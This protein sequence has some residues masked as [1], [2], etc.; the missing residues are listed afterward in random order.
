MTDDPTPA[1]SRPTPSSAAAEYIRGLFELLGDRDPLAVQGELVPALRAAI[2]GLADAGLRRA[3]RAGKWSIAQVIQHLADSEIVSGYRYRAVIAQDGIALAGYDQ[4]AW[5]DRLAYGEADVEAALAAL[6]ELRAANLRLLSR[7]REEEWRR[8]G[9]HAERG[10]E[11]VRQLARLVAGHDLVHRRQIERIKTA[12]GLVAAPPAREHR[13]S[14][15]LPAPPERAF[16]ALIT[17]SAIRRWWQA[18]RAVVIAEPGGAWAA[19]WGTD[20]DDPDYATAATL[21]VFEPPRRLVL[22]DYRYR[23]RAG[24]LPF[25][26][27]FRVEFTIRAAE[28]GGS[29]LE[30]VQSGFPAGPEADAHLAGCE[31]GWRE[32]LE[33]LRRFLTETGREDR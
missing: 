23:A 19:A 15:E 28:S 30:V 11:S 9:L 7:L 32:T 18:D 1:D 33:G 26:A 25:E 29:V 13:R 22:A 5:A 27:D 17:P 24:R 16:V 8:A 6:A 14:I 20:E 12:H 31:T 2:A 10:R 3:E 21:E 4:D